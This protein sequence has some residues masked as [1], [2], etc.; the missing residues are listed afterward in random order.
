MMK[1]SAVRP[2][3]TISYKFGLGPQ[4]SDIPDHRLVRLVEGP[5]G[6]SPGR[7]LDLGCGTGRNP[8]YLARHGWDTVGIEIV[9]YAHR[10]S[11]R[12]PH[13]KRWLSAATPTTSPPTSAGLEALIPSLRLTFGE[14]LDRHALHT[15]HV[16]QDRPQFRQERLAALSEIPR[17][18][19]QALI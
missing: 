18:L 19:Q 10:S 14:L 16:A 9:G 3:G 6:L 8:I 12:W 11:F 2:L 1:N 13:R 4:P 17:S 5:D 7:D 15:V